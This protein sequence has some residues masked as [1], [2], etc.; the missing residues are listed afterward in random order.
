MPYQ[1]AFQRARLAYA[2]LG[3]IA[4]ASPSAA[5]TSDPADDFLSSFAGIRAADL[6]IAAA[7]VLIDGDILQLGGVMFDR[8]GISPQPTYV[9]GID[10][11]A[12]TPG[13]F[14]GTPAVGANVNFDAVLA[15]GTDGSGQV[16]AF[17][18]GAPPTVTNLAA[19]TIA[20]FGSVSIARIPLSLL[21]S[22]GASVNAYSYNLW[23]RSGPGN[24]LIADLASSR[25]FL[26][27]GVPEPESWALLIIGFGIVGVTLRRRVLADA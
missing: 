10:R 5:V 24:E 16:I 2:L 8:I 3:C 13:L 22:R 9:W 17:N 25:N 12:G 4:G 27:E 14:A 26:A 15:F 11:G 1:T 23:T 20:V 7:V 21:P 6:D 19:G 18:D